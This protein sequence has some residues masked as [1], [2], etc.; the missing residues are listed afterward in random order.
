MEGHPW[1]VFRGVIIYEI[2]VSDEHTHILLIK[3]TQS[4]RTLDI[5]TQNMM[6]IVLTTRPRL[7]HT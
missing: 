1:N 2:I 6:S 5:P 4:A 7:A 3:T